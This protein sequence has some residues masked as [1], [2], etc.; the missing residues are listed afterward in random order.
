MHRSKRPKFQVGDILEDYIRDHQGVEEILYWLVLEAKLV[1]DAHRDY[2]RE[3]KHTKR[4]SV[5]AKKLK[6]KIRYDFEYR[7]ILKSLNI[8]NEYGKIWDIDC[9][10][11]D[12]FFIIKKVG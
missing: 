6:Q 1:S 2:R 11:I 9:T 10:A 4:P 12:K 7:Y 3:K 5:R 8:S